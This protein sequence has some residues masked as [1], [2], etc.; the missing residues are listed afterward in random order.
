M[1]A[2]KIL[3]SFGD[4]IALLFASN[5]LTEVLSASAPGSK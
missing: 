2:G 3:I 5:S 4:W 1:M